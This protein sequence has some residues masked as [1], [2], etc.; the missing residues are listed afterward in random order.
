MTSPQSNVHC[1]GG[2]VLQ[3]W[4]SKQS[5]WAR[6]G[7]VGLAFTDH[8][9]LLVLTGSGGVWMFPLEQGAPSQP[10]KPLLSVKVVAGCPALP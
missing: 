8:G 4:P 7:L 10:Q 6:D 1:R 2:Q 3:E 5:K 9:A